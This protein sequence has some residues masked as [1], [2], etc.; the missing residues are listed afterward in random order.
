M[1]VKDQFNELELWEFIKTK[2]NL[3]NSG[4]RQN[5]WSNHFLATHYLDTLDQLFNTMFG[6]SFK[7]GKDCLHLMGEDYVRRLIDGPVF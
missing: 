5:W 7:P 1:T 4:I 2:F 3:N 6:I